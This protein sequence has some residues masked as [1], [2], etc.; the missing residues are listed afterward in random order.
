MTHTSTDHSTP[1]AATRTRVRR[2]GVVGATLLAAEATF[3]V[4]RDGAGIDLAAGGGDT[5]TRVGPVAVAVTA[6]LAGLAGW[7][8]LALLE[9]FT[10]RGRLL[11]TVVAVLAFG[12]SLL[13]P[14]GGVDADARLGLAALH[15]VTA[16]VLVVGLS[17]TARTVPPRRGRSTASGSGGPAVAR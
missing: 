1:P 17:W 13:G 11:W 7:G 12:V 16:A 8:L 15:L 14:A 3:F 4:L 6:V 5:L 9:R 2:L 10:S